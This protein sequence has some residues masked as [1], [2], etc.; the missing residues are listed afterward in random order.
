MWCTPKSS[1]VRSCNIFGGELRRRFN[2]TSLAFFPFRI[3]SLRP[4]D[5]SIAMN[6]D[7]SDRHVRL[8]TCL[9]EARSKVG[10][11]LGS[12]SWR[13]V[14]GTRTQVFPQAAADSHLTGKLA[15]PRWRKR[16][17]RTRRLDDDLR[18]IVERSDPEALVGIVHDERKRTVGPMLMGRRPTRRSM[19]AETSTQLCMRRARFASDLHSVEDSLRNE[20]ILFLLKNCHFVLAITE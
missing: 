6:I 5:P 2:S 11:P 1:I 18:Y 8:V 19:S 4:A 10:V 16:G 20:M 9:F 3:P 13:L 17:P 12:S 7:Q 14:S 15:G